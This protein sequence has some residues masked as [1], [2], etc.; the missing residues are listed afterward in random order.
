LSE[1]AAIAV[2]G[3]GVIGLSIAFR[4]AR[5]NYDVLLIDRDEPGHAA[6]FGNA[7]H[8]AT[9]QIFPLASPSTVCSA[10]RLLL[11]DNGPLSVRPE[12]AL[13]IAPWLTRFT[14]A[15]RPDAFRR[16]TAALSALQSG[17]M[18]SIA[19]LCDEAGLSDMLHRRGH[20]VLVESKR[21]MR[22]VEEQ[23]R[24]FKKHGIDA[25]WLDSN[26]VAELAPE[27]AHDI[28]GALHVEHTG[29]VCDPILLSEGLHRAFTEAGGRTMKA[30]V[31]ETVPADGGGFVVQL[32]SGQV[33]SDRLVISAG[34]WSGKF[35]QQL[36]S[37]VPLDTERG[38]NITAEGFHPQF[39]VSIASFERMTIMTPMDG[40]LRITGFVEFGGLEL[41]PKK[42]SLR[43]LKRHLQQLLPRSDMP[44]MSEWMGFRPSLP[45]HLPVIGKSREH[46]NAIFAFGH[47]HLGLT[48]AGITAD[49]VLEL[50]AGQPST[51]DLQPYRANRF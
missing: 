29:H 1:K 23:H 51:I 40:G 36:G 22:A 9:E 32:D 28:Q 47:Q 17:A 20:L 38:Y 18:E 14:W 6:S 48:L 43:K 41:P 45:D 2:V 30:E 33:R 11:S 42:S 27:M 10:P 19:R 37:P 44:N 31:R 49:L 16:G 35:A 50:V 7:G 26:R 21:S 12:Y 15:S 39:N 24:K 34:A 8:I 5:E 4:L 3:A 46:T 13:N 25:R